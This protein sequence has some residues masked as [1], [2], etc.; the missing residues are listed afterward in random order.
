MAETYF[1]LFYDMD[2]SDAAGCEEVMEK[3]IRLL[4]EAESYEKI[5]EM[6]SCC[7]SL[8]LFHPMS[9]IEYRCGEYIICDWLR[10][11]AENRMEYLKLLNKKGFSI[12]P[13]YVDARIVG[14]FCV[15][16]IRV[17]GTNG[18][19]LIPIS[20]GE[21]L[22]TDEVRQVAYEDVKRLVRAS[23]V[24]AC[25]RAE[26]GQPWFITPGTHR[27]VLGYMPT[28]YPLEKGEERTVMERVY[29]QLYG[30]SPREEDL[31]L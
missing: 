13:Q 2:V 23:L 22:L 17:H 11:G 4:H 27:L 8:E 26:R 19:A 1:D 3:F 15:L 24:D 16:V 31:L 20:E 14:D 12:Y 21:H 18:Q 28:L 6:L 7:V 25:L 29:R 10:F 30:R 5:R 9:N